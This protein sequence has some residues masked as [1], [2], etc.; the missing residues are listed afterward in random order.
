M[1]FCVEWQN[2]VVD[3][4]VVSACLPIS[5][6]S[7]LGAQL[8]PQSRNIHNESNY[9][10]KSPVVVKINMYELVICPG[11]TLPLSAATDSRSYKE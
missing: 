3:S 5:T 8:L 9:D 7:P 4:S 11:C 2:G 10:S 6:P 1:Y